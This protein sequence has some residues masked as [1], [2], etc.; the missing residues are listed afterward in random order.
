MQRDG[1]FGIHTGET[2][3]RERLRQQ[4]GRDP[5]APRKRSGSAGAAFR[6]SGTPDA[7]QGEQPVAALPGQTDCPG[8]Q[9][10]LFAGKA[11]KTAHDVQPGGIFP[12]A[13]QT[14][15]MLHRHHS[16]PCLEDGNSMPRAERRYTSVLPV[17][18]HRGGGT[19]RG[20]VTCRMSYRRICFFIDINVFFR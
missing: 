9:K 2:T 1:G 6:A 20:A 8:L 4:P 19:T 14:V 11:Q 13:Q 18:L 7:V 15:R 16:F 17:F 5:T 10:L 12:A 3:H